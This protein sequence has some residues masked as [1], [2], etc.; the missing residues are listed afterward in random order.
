MNDVFKGRL[1]DPLL[2]G[3]LIT[4]TRLTSVRGKIFDLGP[5]EYSR[6]HCY[7]VTASLLSL[8]GMEINQQAPCLQITVTDES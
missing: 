6:D 1:S 2:M 4:L 7:R 8:I 5:D 3:H